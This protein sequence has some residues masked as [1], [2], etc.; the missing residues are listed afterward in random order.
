M[1]FYNS[2][3]SAQAPLQYPPGIPITAILPR[4]K[5]DVESFIG[6]PSTMGECERC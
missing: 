1:K 4:T 6:K 3:A 5:A 2:T